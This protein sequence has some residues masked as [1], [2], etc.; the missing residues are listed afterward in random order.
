MDH[1]SAIEVIRRF[2]VEKIGDTGHS[3]F[4]GLV[5]TL[6][7]QATRQEFRLSSSGRQ[8]GRDAGSESGYATA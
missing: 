7:Q 3:G 5:A 6:L 2:L 4:E 1:K 8:A